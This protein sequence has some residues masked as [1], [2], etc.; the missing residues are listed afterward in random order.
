MLSKIIR[1]CLGFSTCSF[2]LRAR[3][4][5]DESRQLQGCYNLSKFTGD[6][7]TREQDSSRVFQRETRKLDEDVEAAYTTEVGRPRTRNPQPFSKRPVSSFRLCRHFSHPSLAFVSFVLRFPRPM[8]FSVP[9]THFSPGFYIPSS[10]NHL[11]A[12][13][14][15]HPPCSSLLSS[16][17]GKL[18]FAGS[19]Y[20]S[21]PTLWDLSFSLSRDSTQRAGSSPHPVPARLREKRPSPH[22]AFTGAQHHPG[23]PRVQRRE[24]D[25]RRVGTAFAI[26]ELAAP[27]KHGWGCSILLSNVRTS[28]SILS[29]ECVSCMKHN[30]TGAYLF[31]SMKKGIPLFSL[32][33]GILDK[34]VGFFVV[35]LSYVQRIFGKSNNCFASVM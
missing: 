15:R 33:L 12:S 35:L 25:R 3:L 28:L 26:R 11:P 19:F 9:L 29:H 27:P 5:T 14:S 16:A 20:G 22:L 24:R 2:S 21:R 8:S 23:F 30:S 31:C 34:I 4:C 7:A 10:F 18:V 32:H 6:L 1:E 17:D 13:R